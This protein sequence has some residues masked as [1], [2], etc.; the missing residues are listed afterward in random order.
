MSESGDLNDF[1]RENYLQFRASGGDVFRS[2]V[3]PAGTPLSGITWDFEGTYRIYDVPGDATLKTLTLDY[4]FSGDDYFEL[5]VLDDRTLEL[6][7]PDS[8]TLYEFT[9]R[10]YREFL[11][12]AATDSRKRE[13]V[14]LPKMQ[15][16]RR[17]PLE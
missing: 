5:Y 9:G 1:D 7:H 6:Y 15:V 8:G 12:D 14:A 16:K 17:R 3:D 2:S 4:D 13:A 10:G 11:K